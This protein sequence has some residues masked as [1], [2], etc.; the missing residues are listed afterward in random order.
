MRSR[1]LALALGCLAA[2]IVAARAA[3]QLR[4]ASPDGRTL[5]TVQLHEGRLRYAVE[6]DARPVVLPS[7]LGF[8]LRGAPPLRDGL[9]ITGSAERSADETWMQPWGE[10]ARVRD[11][12]RELR[13]SVEETAAPGRRFDVVFRAFDDGIGFRYELPAQP[14]LGDFVIADELTEFTLATDGRAW[15]IPAFRP[16]RYEYLYSASPVSRLDTVHTPLTIEMQDGLH[17]VIHEAN[18]VDYAAMTLYGGREQNRTLRT[19]LSPWADGTKVRGRTPFVTPWR[20]IQLAD[21]AEALA[22]S[23]LGLNL[24]PPSVVASTSWIRPMKYVGIWWGMHI[25]T[26]TWGSGPRHGATTAN[27]RRY[28]DF[29]ADNGFGG[30]LVEGW[31]VGWDGDWMA[32]ADEFSFTRPYPDY[33][34]RGLAAYAR[35]RGVELIA[36]NETSMGIANY[37]RQLDGAFALYDSLD[38]NAVKTGYVGDRTREGHSHHGQYMVRHWRKVLETA[39][40]HEIMVNAH[41]PIKPTGERR[42]YPNMMTREG[43]RGQEYNAWG[44]EGGNPPEHETILFFT[45]MLAGPMDFTPGIFDLLLD[46][47]DGPPRTPAQSRPRTTLAKQLALYVVL[48]SP[49]QMAADLPESYAGRPELKFVRDVAVDW[50]ETRVLDGKIGDYVVVARRARGADEWYVGAIT[51]EEGRSFEIPLSFLPTGRRWVA[52]IYADGPGAHWMTNPLPVAISQRAV[53]SAATLRLALAPGGGQAIRITP[54][55]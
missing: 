32:N 4:V 9:R 42:T 36:H 3:A 1:S 19:H 17:V 23:V 52:E 51:D 38:I 18:L 54:A 40:R 55:R 11:A 22:P 13:V 41:E 30:V 37:E 31:N 43:A 33:D 39:A 50:E 29:A 8:E 24:N 15:W 6:R 16:N 48:W 45:R 12:H 49:L 26:M 7:L 35:S 34:L 47:A 21:S 28:I 10:V 53:T 20:T 25:N 46:R 27:T 14:A 2:A 5:V 44:G